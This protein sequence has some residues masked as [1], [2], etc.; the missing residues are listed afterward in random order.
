MG[1]G[2]VKHF[3]GDTAKNNAFK[4][5][6]GQITVDT[7]YGTARVHDGIQVGGFPLAREI[8]TEAVIANAAAIVDLQKRLAQAEV[9]IDV[10]SSG[11][12]IKASVRVATTANLTASFANN[13]LT[14][15][16]TLAA[17]TIDTV[18]LTLNDRV[19]VWNQT[20]ALQNGIYT[21][22]AVGSASVAWSL[23]RASD[24]NTSALVVKG[25]FCFVSEGSANKNK[26]FALITSGTIAL[27]T[28]TL[29]FTQVSAAGQLIGGSGL[30]NSGQALDVVTASS[31]RI[32]V[33][34][35]SI[36][37][38]TTGVI[39][40]TYDRV[41]VDSWGRV[42]SGSNVSAVGWA[43]PTG[44]ANRQTYQTSTA[45]VV[46]LAERLKALIDDL[47]AIGLLKP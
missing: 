26:G 32:S 33:L 31:S 9:N 25:M 27:N 12:D 29:T 15:T 6:P 10:A 44:Q 22:T 16:G 23:T 38:A 20:S 19:L 30:V 47:T 8:V 11:L 35:D 46:A 24:A 43:S 41:Q 42:I 34:P 21:V 13:V 39:P 28:T 40:A 4:G 36:D 14:N 7:E 18:A 3:R 37:L 17:L 45:T 1:I 5:L 2:T